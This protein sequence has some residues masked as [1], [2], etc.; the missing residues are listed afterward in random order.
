[1]TPALKSRA[2]AWLLVVLSA[3]PGC[4]AYDRSG[5][6]ANGPG[7][8][9]P[10]ADATTFREAQDALIVQL[11]KAAK[12]PAASEIVKPTGA[13]DL[14]FTVAADVSWDMVIRAG[15]DYA[16][17]R[18]ESYLH[19]LYR[20]D[21]DR[22]TAVTQTGL[23]GGATAGVQAALGKAAKEVAIVAILFGLAG[24]TIDN[25]ASNL[26]YELE[27]SSVRTLVKAQ[28]AHYRDNLRMGYQDRPAAMTALRGYA[29]LCVPASIESEVNLAV[30]STQPKAKPGN[31]ET[32]QPPVVTN[33]LIA[34]T[35]ATFAP[36]DSSEKLDAFVNPG[37]V[38]NRDNDQRL[39][40]FMA[41]HRVTGISTPIFIND[42]KY[43]DLRKLAVKAFNL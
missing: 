8:D 18:C 10:A 41:D 24:S 35:T 21:R 5:L 36:D 29:L 33:S 2:T 30:R 14:K 22:K 12:P 9:L 32:G 27:P 1:M 26:L 42:P 16:D 6:A 39:L 3:L 11:V 28:Q 15:M 4:A 43:A 31:P 40:A 37:G 19:A 13:E 25:V 20:L 34:V 23:L 17:V 7:S 38:L